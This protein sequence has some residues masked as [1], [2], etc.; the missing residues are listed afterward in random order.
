MSSPPVTAPPSETVAE[1]AA[2]MR[3]HEVSSVVVVDGRRPIGIMTERDLIRFAA[4][5]AAAAG[6]QGPEGMPHEPDVVAPDLDAAGALASLDAH[7]YR[8]IPV[9]EA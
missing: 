5:G 4:T 2:R 7:G 3:D 6:T 1:A 9:V 8:H